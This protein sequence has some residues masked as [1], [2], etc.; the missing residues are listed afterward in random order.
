MTGM[1]PRKLED[2]IR[3]SLNRGRI[4][5]VYG[6]RRIGKTTLVRKILSEAP[7]AEQ[8]YLN[9]D[10]IQTRQD[11]TPY[12]LSS[13]E[14]AVGSAKMIIIDE[15]QRV[16]NIGLTLKILI[17][18]HP[19]L[20]IIATGS[21]SF[22]LANKIKEPLTGRSIELHLTPLSLTEI[23]DHFGYHP[24]QLEGV[25]EKL[26][27]YGSYPSVFEMTPQQAERELLTISSQY[28]YKDTL[29]LV[30]IRQQQLLPRLLQALALQIGNEVSYHELGI[31]LG[32]KLETVA[33]YI[34]LLEQSFII[35]RL[36]AL[37]GNQRS[38]LSNRKRKVYFY[39]L[40]AR[41]ALINNFNKLSLRDDVG[42]LWESLCVSERRKLHLSN[43][44]FVDMYYWRGVYGE[45]DMIESQGG[46]WRA[47]ECKW[48]EDKFKTPKYFRE[49]FPDIKV[50]LLNQ[51]TLPQ[52]IE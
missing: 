38:Q 9:C 47:F 45:V 32:A 18:A 42:A 3:N 6:P 37:T 40:G 19:E 7:K 41:N 35:Y 31:L 14:R 33:R 44:D 5:I 16:E 26:M 52:F 49:K 50:E 36:P 20:N 48:N 12:S 4:I 23:K 21:S 24:R 39:D 29:E 13:L 34:T 1:I 25:Y 10:E 17:D 11:L 8:L 27:R 51:K 46:K 28:V 2:N 43:Q 30:E 15:A 22:D